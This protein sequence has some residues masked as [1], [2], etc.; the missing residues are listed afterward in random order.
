MTLTDGTGGQMTVADL[1]EAWNRLALA[2]RREGVLREYAAVVETTEGGALHLHL[3]ATG[4]YVKQARLSALAARSGFGAVADIR[5]VKDD[6]Q[7]ERSARYIAKEVAG[8]VSKGKAEALASKTA[9]RR[10]PLRTSRGWGL[11][12][13]AAEKL[14]AAERATEGAARDVGPW[15]HLQALADGSL[16]V[17]GGGDDLPRLLP[18]ETSPNGSGV[19]VGA[20]RRLRVVEPSNERASAS[21][22]GARASE[23]E[24]EDGTEEGGREVPF[25]AGSENAHARA[26]PDLRSAA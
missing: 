22:S 25:L 19:A 1:Y 7:G 5:A 23:D 18:P 9:Q 16:R 2:L 14:L 15:L 8:Y 3:L 21:A 24:G 11:S 6:A 4:E 12:L 10:R 17:R 26:G 20:A 13:A